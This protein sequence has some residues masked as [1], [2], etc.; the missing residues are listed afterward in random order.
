MKKK[1]QAQGCVG[2]HKASGKYQAII[3]KSWNKGKQKSIGVFE[4]EEEAWAAIAEYK[5]EHVDS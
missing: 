2:I 4:T 1:Q 5:A 3:P